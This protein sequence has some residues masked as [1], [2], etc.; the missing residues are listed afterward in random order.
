MV[1]LLVI[2]FTKPKD[3]RRVSAHRTVILFYSTKHILAKVTHFFKDYR[4]TTLQDSASYS[5][6]VSSISDIREAAMM[7]TYSNTDLERP[8]FTC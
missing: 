8:L 3:K 2:T 7:I 4:H 5:N 6:T 1:H